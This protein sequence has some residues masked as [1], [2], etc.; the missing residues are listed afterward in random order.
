MRVERDG[1]AARRQSCEGSTRRDVD[2]QGSPRIRGPPPHAANIPAHGPRA[3]GRLALGLALRGGGT[4]RRCAR[5]DP[6]RERRKVERIFGH[7][8]DP[9]IVRWLAAAH[10]VEGIVS[11]GERRDLTLLFVIAAAKEAEA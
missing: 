7:Y 5:V 1:K 9:R 8:V 11:R 3:C 4:L 10:S 6:Q 2:S